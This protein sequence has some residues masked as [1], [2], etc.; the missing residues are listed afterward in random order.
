MG[1]LW[2]SGCPLLVSVSA[3]LSPFQMTRQSDDW[4]TGHMTLF[5]SIQFDA[6]SRG[7]STGAY[8]SLYMIQCSY[9]HFFISALASSPSLDVKLCCILDLSMRVGVGLNSKERQR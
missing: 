5:F 1:Q 6:P 9:S 8:M 7:M 3:F 4:M 2:T